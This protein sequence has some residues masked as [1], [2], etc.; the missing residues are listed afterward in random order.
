MPMC[1]CDM[2]WHDMIWYDMTLYLFIW[3]NGLSENQSFIICHNF[4]IKGHLWPYMTIAFFWQGTAATHVSPELAWTIPVVGHR[5]G[6]MNFPRH[7][8]PLGTLPQFHGKPQKPCHL[9][10]QISF[11]TS[12]KKSPLVWYVCFF[13]DEQISSNIILIIHHLWQQT[14]D[15]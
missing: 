2:T 12:T 13:A 11:V 8:R 1:I 15:N 3:Y 7:G 6:T 10:H 9:G 4:T 5:M 14:K